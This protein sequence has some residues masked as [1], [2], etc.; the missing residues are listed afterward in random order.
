MALVEGRQLYTIGYRIKEQWAVTHFFLE[1]PSRP[2]RGLKIGVLGEENFNFPLP[3][4]Q[5]RNASTTLALLA[6][7]ATTDVKTGLVSYQ[8]KRSLGH[9]KI[10]QLESEKS[11]ASG[12]TFKNN[13]NMFHQQSCNPKSLLD[14]Q[15]RSL[16]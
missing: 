12:T 11:P 8:K 4:A 1:K 6:L 7:W 5:L 16:G 13:R 2:N 14:H 15:Q 10:S 3:S 9:K